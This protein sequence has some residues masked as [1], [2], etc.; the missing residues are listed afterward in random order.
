ML[1]NV[2]NEQGGLEKH[3]SVA[4]DAAV[5]EERKDQ[6]PNLRM[7]R[8]KVKSQGRKKGKKECGNFTLETLKGDHHDPDRGVH[9]RGKIKKG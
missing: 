3:L 2:L 5:L 6:H 4:S 7:C 8:G 9:T 1:S